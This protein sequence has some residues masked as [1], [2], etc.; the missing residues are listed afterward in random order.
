MTQTVNIYEAKAKLSALIEAAK[1]GEEII[2]AKAGEPQ[3]TLTPVAP[4]K[5]QLR[6]FGQNILGITY[7]APDFNDPLPDE[8]WSG[9]LIPGE[10]E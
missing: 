9:P 10:E 7:I 4:K 5:K 2:I 8:M 3:V 1:N 6:Q